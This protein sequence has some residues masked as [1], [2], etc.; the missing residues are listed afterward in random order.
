MRRSRVVF[1][2]E[3]HY[4]T[5][6]SNPDD[7]GRAV[8]ARTNPVFGVLYAWRETVNL[9]L[10]AGQGFETPSFTELAYRPDGSAGLNFAL[11]PAVSRH[12]ETGL[13]AYAGPDTR[14][15][16]ALFRVRTEDEIVSGPAAAPGRATFRNAERTARDGMELSLEHRFGPELDVYFAG[17]LLDARFE[18]YVSFSGTD[19]SGRALPGVPRTML[20]GELRW[21][22]RSNV[23]TVLEARRVGA[24]P[25][26]DANSDTAAA[27][28]V[29][30]GR[31]GWEKTGRGWRVEPFLRLDN[32]LDKNYIGSVIVNANNGAYFEPVPRRQYTLGLQARFE[33]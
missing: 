19:L 4:V 9:Y 22:L 20:H 11:R 23:R 18:D 3:D 5:G 15:N 2:S 17:T 28:T 32:L 10:N 12:V 30:N 13:K 25:V 1:E 16:A 29:I 14:I 21:R 7:S 8:Y 27:Y 31:I 33:L 26:D 6:P 24:I